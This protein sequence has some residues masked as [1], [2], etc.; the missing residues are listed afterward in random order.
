MIGVTGFGVAQ[1]SSSIKGKNKM[2]IAIIGA[3]WSGLSIMKVLLA[4]GHDVKA[5]EANSDVGG[6]WNPAIAYH[7]LKIHNSLFSCMFEGETPSENRNRLKRLYSQ[8]IYALSQAYANDNKLYGNIRFNTKVKSISYSSESGISTLQILDLESGKVDVQEFD[9]VIST[10]FNS[11]RVPEF[12]RQEE[13]S[14][15]IYHT[16][17]IKE[18]VVDDI[19]LKN[20]KVVVL[21]G[22]KS[23]SDIALMFLDRNYQV[24][25]LYRKAYWF[26]DASKSNLFYRML[27]YIAPSFMFNELSSKVIFSLMSMIG[28]IKTPGKKHLDFRKYHAGSIYGHDLKTLKDEPEHIEGE[29]DHLDDHEIVLESGKRVPCDV[30]ICATGCDPVSDRIDLKVDG[31]SLNYE[32]VKYMYRSSI[33][34]ELPKLCFTGY[35]P[36]G[37]GPLN[38]FHRAAWL[39][40]YFPKN[41]STD[42]L[43]E[44]AMEEGAHE[45]GFFKSMPLFDSSGYLFLNMR[46][47]FSHFVKDGFISQREI[48]L[49]FYNLRVKLRYKPFESAVKIIN[50]HKVNG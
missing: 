44:L 21:G 6:T 17:D 34:P 27:S 41:L 11:P 50:Q 30:L 31:V 8:D 36:F 29:V 24:K 47:K 40:W 14:G 5:F 35:F 16:N 15:D 49:F 45:G 2:K 28:L 10:Q 13:F 37:M 3:G 19:I 39:L 22:S 26:N 23:G 9:F 48:I 18:S 38:G 20:K 32:D 25:W 4:C 1:T 42:E 43:K 12:K 7:G 33:I 46:R